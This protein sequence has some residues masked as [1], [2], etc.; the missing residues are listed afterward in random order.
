MTRPAA[1][2]IP[3]STWPA[4]LLF[5]TGGCTDPR[6]PAAPDPP[7]PVPAV[8]LAVA[9]SHALLGF[10][11]VEVTWSS[12]DASGC[13]AEGAWSGPRRTEGAYSLVPDATG[14]L[15]FTLVCSGPGG[16]SDPV[17]ADVSVSRFEHEACVN[18]R[19]ENL[20][21]GGPN[22]PPL[23]GEL[24]PVNSVGVLEDP[25]M[26]AA[27]AFRS[28]MRSSTERPR[29]ME[30]EL[31][32]SNDLPVTPDEWSGIYGYPS[33]G[34]GANT[35]W[36]PGQSTTA[37]LPTRLSEVDE[38]LRVRFDVEMDAP[39]SRYH[40]LLILNLQPTAAPDRCRTFDINI[41]MEFAGAPFAHDP[42]SARHMNPGG[43]VFRSTSALP[44]EESPHHW[45]PEDPTSFYRHADF[46]AEDFVREGEVHLRPFLDFVADVAGIPS[47]FYLQA[48]WFGVEFGYG[49][50]E[51]RFRY[52]VIPD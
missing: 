23:I 10:D 27:Y 40:I 12:T 2:S 45:C 49:S 31:E 50:G 4:I 28:C 1:L 46:A 20:W 19:V 42:N 36:Q 11:T 8:S 52:E 33:V 34:F 6:D 21:T 5:T 47:D 13:T 39:D 43:I 24:M 14:S 15:E 18:E 7:P 25:A 22:P 26:Q 3:H 38:N 17:A 30:V 29:T 41:N 44:Y 48:V 51:A 9:P 16:V 32:W 35:S 37:L